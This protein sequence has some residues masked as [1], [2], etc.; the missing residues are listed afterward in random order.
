MKI[1]GI[2]NVTVGMVVSKTIYGT[3]GQNLLN[4]GTT[5]TEEYLNRLHD[6]GVM[7]L[8]I[9]DANTDDV[10]ID[11]VVCEQTRTEAASLV[12]D[13]TEKTRLGKG[14]DP[15]KVK[16]IINCIVD[17]LL[18]HREILIKLVDIRSV[19]DYLYFH[20]VNVAVLS[21]IVG[22]RLNYAQSKLQELMIGAL[23]HDIGKTIIYDQTPD[24][25]NLFTLDHSSEMKKHPQLG[26]E[27]LQKNKNLSILSAHVALQHHE[28]IDGQGYPRN[29]IGQEIHEY[30][31]IVAITN[32]YDYLT[33]DLPNKPRI[34]P[35][36]AVE[37][38]MINA[39]YAFDPDMVNTFIQ[40]VALYPEG[41]MVR[42]NTEQIAII[43]KSYYGF[44][45]RPRIRIIADKNGYEL[46]VPE[47][48]ELYKSPTYFIAE[49]LDDGF[50]IKSL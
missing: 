31:K 29:L 37:Y 24:A 18:S 21:S 26:F 40:T 34:P 3:N 9:T 49:V 15:R 2:D 46:P 30:S 32:A 25:I 44:P 12:K 16:Q 11:D 43:I 13:I 8:Y 50:Q 19:D 33:T 28:R 14:I 42:L 1:M 35:H 38:L 36:Q 20:S 6:L 10:E 23:M 47:T 17:D 39:G 45:T 5:L 7:S 41:T 22:I 27:V 48:I 4:A